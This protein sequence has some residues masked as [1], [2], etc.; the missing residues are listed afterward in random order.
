MPGVEDAVHVP[1]KSAGVIQENLSRLL[2]PTYFDTY[3]R[4]AST[5]LSGFGEATT[6]V[7]KMLSQRTSKPTGWLSLEGF[8][9][10]IHVCD[11]D[12][13]SHHG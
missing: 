9:N 7:G 13:L 1:G 5:R 3:A 6:K 10:N 12:I 8:H 4:F 2:N 11:F